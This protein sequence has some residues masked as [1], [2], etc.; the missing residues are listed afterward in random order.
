MAFLSLPLVTRDSNVA[1]IERSI[2]QFLCW[3]ACRYLNNT[4]NQRQAV[5]VKICYFTLTI[6]PS[7]RVTDAKN[8][9]LYP[10]KCGRLQPTKSPSGRYSA[11]NN[12]RSEERRVGKEWRSR[13]G[14]Q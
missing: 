6:L 9:R 13:M 12:D 2:L 11:P 3:L 1:K 8:S 10:V 5:L 14:R 4:A 7:L